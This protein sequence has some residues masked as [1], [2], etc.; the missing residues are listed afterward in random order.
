[1]RVPK[2]ERLRRFSRS[3]RSSI[4]SRQR[5]RRTRHRAQYPQTD[6][7][8]LMQRALSE[9]FY[10]D[11]ERRILGIILDIE[12]GIR[13]GVGSASSPAITIIISGSG[14]PE[15]TRPPFAAIFAGVDCH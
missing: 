5:T 10:I 8:P 6:C 2:T 15:K 9:G 14:L 1:K 12:I 13:S 4:Q 3:R 11:V 7:E